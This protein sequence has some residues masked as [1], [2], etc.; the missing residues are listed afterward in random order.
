MGTHDLSDQY[1]M[2]RQVT[3]K[4]V[5]IVH[6]DNAPTLIDEAISTAL[7]ERKPAYI[8]IACNLSAAPCPEPAPIDTLLASMLSFQPT[9]ARASDRRRRAGQRA[10][11]ATRRSRFCWPGRT[12][13][14]T[15]PST[16]SGNWPKALGCAVAVMPNAK[17][18]FPK[19]TRNTRASTG[20]R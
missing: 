4:A 6:P 8:E 13:A 9:N 1:E 3:C 15:A 20:A 14:P 18:F 10:C 5:R 2:C 7:R 19:T 12:C 16:P 11:G 17:G